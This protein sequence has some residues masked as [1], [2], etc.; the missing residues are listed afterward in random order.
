MNEFDI[1]VID[2][3]IIVGAEALELIKEAK[4]LDLRMKKNNI[5][6]AKFREALMQAMESNGVKSFDCDLCRATY[7]AEHTS[8]RLDTKKLKAEHPKI[9]KK[10]TVENPVK[11]SL[12]LE[13]KE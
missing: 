5:A 3:K 2:G 11:A 13:F 1:D 4:R 10:Y 7:I 8:S 9:A 12:K 6:M